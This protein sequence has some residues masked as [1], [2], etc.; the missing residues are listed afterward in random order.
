MRQAHDYCAVQNRATNQIDTAAENE[1]FKSVNGVRPLAAAVQF[2]FTLTAAGSYNY[3]GVTPSISSCI[4][5][6]V[7]G[8]KPAFR[9]VRY[10]RIML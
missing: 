7:L 8:I 5:P 3:Y 9:S 4:R 1:S 10:C 2:W 6:K